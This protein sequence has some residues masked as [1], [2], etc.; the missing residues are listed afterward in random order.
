M[1]NSFAGDRLGRKTPG[2]G[3]SFCFL[4]RE[5]GREHWTGKA[6]VV[7]KGVTSGFSCWKLRLRKR[8]LIKTVMRFS[9]TTLSLVFSSY[10]Q[11]PTRTI[12]CYQEVFLTYDQ[13][14]W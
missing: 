9:P 3:V 13:S 14:I 10:D 8:K 5:Q 4:Y 12:F 11:L 2:Q 1:F 7:E 6:G